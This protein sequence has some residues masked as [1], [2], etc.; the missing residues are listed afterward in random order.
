MT[1]DSIF[2]PA[3]DRILTAVALGGTAIAAMREARIDSDT[4]AE[5]LRDK[6]F[7]AALEEARVQK[8]LLFCDQA[9]AL[10]GEALARLRVLMSDPEATRSLN[11]RAT[12]KVLDTALRFLHPDTH[13][14]ILPDAPQNP[15]PVHKNAQPDPIIRQNAQRPE[16]IRVNK[17]GRNELCPC[18]SGRKYK[19]CCLNGTALPSVG[20][21]PA[22][23]PLPILDP[24]PAP[25]LAG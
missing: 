22:S 11:L 15:K 13:A 1:L 19:H 16:P 3:Q 5:W 4:M 18:G 17:I 23:D 9:E 21:P 25:E 8:Q 10:A 14:L 24:E 6:E 20:A 7:A 12:L 2:T